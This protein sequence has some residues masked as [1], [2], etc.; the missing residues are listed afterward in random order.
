M[1]GD[2]NFSGWYAAARATHFAACLTIFS[3]FVFD[4]FIVG[5]TD[6]HGAAEVALRWR[7]VFGWLLGLAIPAALLS[8][9]AWFLFV[10]A[11]MSGLSLRDAISA[12]VVTVVWRQTQFGRLWMLRAIDLAALAIVAGSVLLLRRS[13]RAN[14]VVSSFALLLA[15]VLVASLVWAGHGQTGGPRRW[16]LSVDAVHLLVSACWPAGLVPLALLMIA[17]RRSFDDHRRR[18]LSAIVR[19]FSA[20][21]LLCVA[22]LAA[23][24]SANAWWLVGSF[25]DL[26]DSDYGRVLLAKIA[27]FC[28]MIALGAVNLFY[29]KPRVV[30][31]PADE[32]STRACDSAGISL[33]R[34]VIAEA[35]FAAAVLG[36]VGILGMLAPPTEHHAHQHHR[37]TPTEQQ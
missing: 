3:A 29:L 25:A 22:L 2:G 23:T 1:F 17:L 31:L 15:A 13:G 16:H 26:I 8:G 21:A 11:E 10:A 27:I 4:R 9:A 19:R 35:A 32:R 12:D 34:S 6:N 14:S 7:R 28:C 37:A 24:G 36:L 18:A 33:R 20:M 30:M 5:R